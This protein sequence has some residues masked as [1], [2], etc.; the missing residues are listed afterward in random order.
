VITN[1]APPRINNPGE[2]AGSI[3]FTESGDDECNTFW[4]CVA[5]H[6]DLAANVMGEMGLIYEPCDAFS[7][8]F[9]GA[10][11]VAY[12]LDGQTDKAMMETGVGVVSLFGG[13]YFADTAETM[14][15]DRGFGE[16]AR[17]FGGMASGTVGGY[18]SGYG[19]ACVATRGDE[20]CYEMGFMEKPKEPTD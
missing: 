10:S 12:L 18:E 17:Q 13:R 2:S 5:V 19:F 7:A 16:G 14:L 11:A 15:A 4:G 20:G 1:P 8:G 3:T 6:L 9:A